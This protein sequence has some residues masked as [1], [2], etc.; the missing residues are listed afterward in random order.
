MKNRHS[1]LHRGLMPKRLTVAVFTALYVVGS[2][3][4]YSNES[5]LP[6]SFGGLSAGHEWVSTQQ[7]VAEDT[8]VILGA[9]S[10]NDAEPGV[11]EIGVQD[12]QLQIRFREWDYL[13]GDHAPE[14]MGW[15]MA[16]PGTYKSDDG[17]IVEVGVV[18][19][20]KPTEEKRNW[21]R[22]SFKNKFPKRPHLFVTPQNSEGDSTFVVR[23]KKV[24]NKGFSVAAFEQEANGKTHATEEQIAYVAIHAPANKGTVD[25]GY[26]PVPFEVKKQ[27]VKMTADAFGRQ[28]MVEE[29]QSRDEETKHGRITASVMLIDGQHLFA[30]DISGRGKDTI[31]LRY[32]MGQLAIGSLK[33]VK[34]S[35]DSID[36]EWDRAVG[37]GAEKITHYQVSRDDVPV[38]STTETQ[39]TDTGLASDTPYQYKVEGLDAAEQPVVS[40]AQAKVKTQAEKV[41]TALSAPMGLSC[42]IR[43][44]R[45]NVLMW[46]APIKGKATTYKIYRNDKLI[47]TSSHSMY[48]DRDLEPNAKSTYYVVA[49]DDNG[50]ESPRSTLTNTSICIRS[51]PTPP[52]GVEDDKEPPTLP[53]NFQATATVDK[54]TLSW[55]D[56]TDN[57]GVAG[58]QIWRN[59][60]QLTTTRGRSLVDPTVKAGT[61]YSYQVAAYDQAANVSPVAEVSVT[62]KQTNTTPEPQPPVEPPKPPVEP[63]Q[64]PV[65]PPKP[66]VEPPKP[67]VEPPKP[68]VEPPQ[69]PVEPPKPPVEPPKPPVEP[70]QP[71]VE[72]PQPPEKPPQPQDTQAPSQPGSLKAVADVTSITLS[73]S[74]ASDDT[75]VTGYRVVRKDGTTETVTGTSFNDTG[76]TSSKAY[77]YQ[78]IALDAA[79][80]ASTP[81]A[82]S[83]TT[84][85]A[86]DTQAPGKPGSL[87]AVP[88]VSSVALSWR[89]A[90]DNTGVTG[91]RVVRNSTTVKT[92]TGTSFNDTGLKS[93]TAYRYQVIALDA[94]G[95]ASSP[96]AASA[97]TK[98]APDTQAPSQPGSLKA[99]PAVSS[100]ALSWRA[101][102]DNTG[103]TGYRVVRNGTTVKTV[104][105][106]SFNDIG[107]KASTAYRYQVIALDAAGN[108]SSPAAASATT[109]KAPDTQAPSKPGSLKAVADVTSITLNWSAATDDTG[110]TGY[111]VVR[112]DG[113]TKTVTGTSFNDTG[114]KSSTAYRYQ[115]IALDAAG[116][117]SSP[118]AAS[119]TTKKAPDTQAP[120]K[121]GSLKAVPA[122]SSVALSWR[123]ATD[124]T[125]VTGYRVVRNGTTVKTVTGTSFNDTG[126]KASTAYR[127]Q[128]IA[129]DAAG[130]ASSP[131]AVSA[132]TKKAP[133]TQGPTT[134]SNFKVTADHATGRISLSWGASRANKPGGVF[135]EITRNGVERE[136]T[137]ETT[138]IDDYLERE[139]DY[140]YTVSAWDAYGNEG[141]PTAGIT[142]RLNKLTSSSGNCTDNT[143]T[144]PADSGDGSLRACIKAASAGGKVIFSKDMKIVL[145][146]QILIGKGVSIDGGSHKVEISGNNATRLFR[147]RT[148]DKNVTFANLTLTNGN[149]D[150]TSDY[151]YVVP[152]E[153]EDGPGE[154]DGFGGAI[155]SINTHL[156]VNNVTFTGNFGGGGGAINFVG[157][158]GDKS[159]TSMLKIRDS[160]FTNNTGTYM[161]GAVALGALQSHS[162]HYS[163]AQVIDTSFENN[164]GG[165]GGAVY[166]NRSFMDFYGS[167]MLSNK[168]GTAGAIYSW[169]GVS[170]ITD[171]DVSGNSASGT[172]GA[173]HMNHAD[174]TVKNSSLNRNTAKGHGGAI[175]FQS[176]SSFDHNRDLRITGSTLSNNSA[177]NGAAI[178]ANNLDNGSFRGKNHMGITLRNTNVTNNSATANNG[179]GAVGKGGYKDK[180][181]IKISGGEVK[182][183]TRD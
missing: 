41:G 36:L 26:G 167:H 100:I 8:V 150:K 127:Y 135:Y 179:V 173:I 110:V 170:T 162:G 118:A 90:T 59:G 109:K 22:F 11:A 67:P 40:S 160:A 5:A 43:S 42:G 88:A 66:P 14:Q 46:G 61:S 25:L 138:F 27:R 104:T 32:G 142:V 159:K 108:A 130:N 17:T 56:S 103:V 141:L 146:S 172:A 83:A 48:E 49:V 161:G 115:V 28:L 57:R 119:A 122:V 58:Y 51:A 126:L 12:E 65:E 114:L 93:S 15:L 52:E 145:K 85:K 23:A 120:S 123:A 78:V 131:A 107:L 31:A 165:K 133:N 98:K 39:F 47:G 69:P 147:I 82:V 63:P 148:A 34:N 124:N 121:P 117:A 87:K 152:G 1:V 177:S 181:T 94:A 106:T 96:A 180:I 77:R 174:L 157:I 16:K 92:V 76:L 102:T 149:A 101:A 9:P 54:V 178:M 112:N 62:T 3:L 84:K 169:G 38:G 136:N 153:P 68:P 33:V 71:P 72:P 80:N 50:N 91:Y 111:R 44:A 156:N 74:A 37:K 6:L 97:T 134:P 60:K 89:A 45:S 175:T 139:K 151:D 176:S 183:N 53:G 154:D 155:W 105:G 171:S 164:K 168:A 64:P 137:R 2:G 7:Q 70:P 55:R 81:A 128:V 116:N 35:S 24:K 125:G 95:N 79:G 75:G 129:L 73:W 144:T 29:E 86:P 18:T 158:G 19:L 166:S 143:V 113:T 99:V 182:G 140:T 10:S 21:K 30:Q 13:D 132:T 20:P 4:S 163:R